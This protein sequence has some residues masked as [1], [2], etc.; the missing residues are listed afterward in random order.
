MMLGRSALTQF[1]V[2][3][4]RTRAA[5]IVAGLLCA[6][7]LWQRF[8]L[9][10]SSAAEAARPT[11]AIPVET[12]L[13]KRADL[14]VELEGLGTVQAF[15]TVKITPRVDG[16]LQR[17]RFVEGQVV[18]RGALLAQ[19]D[20]R[21]YRAVLQQAIASRD[22][23]ANQLANAARDLARYE[24]LAP[25]N[26]VSRQT[27]DTQRAL[28]GQLKAQLEGDRAA[29][30]AARTQLS[31]TTINSPIDGRTGLRLVDPG[32][33]VHASDATGIVIVTQ[34]QPISVIFTFPEDD[35][36]AVSRAL[37]AG[38]VRAVA[39]TRGG[40]K[41]LD[42]GTISVIDN[43]IDPTTG[44]MRLKA[45]FPNLDNR[46]WPG[47]F[48]KVRAQLGTDRHV[49]TIPAAAIQRG[50]EGEFAYVVGPDATV[51]AQQVTT[52]LES[53]ASVVVEKGLRDGARVVTSNQFRLQ[54]GARVRVLEAAQ[55]SS[56]AS[57]GSR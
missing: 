27:L 6:I 21:P 2:G 25:K 1:P 8:A 11:T 28:V 42:R 57:N 52:G 3:R 39:L 43:E 44:T 17:V 40:A 35:L 24:G 30:D 50:P 46:L 22:K 32:N 41:E 19:I 10:P 18:K 33:V 51:K 14:P 13:A 23:D 49:L 55:S 53:G 47:E 4:R 45:T 7:V 12:A 54:P 56:D 29:I 31:Y 26:L 20:P 34:M 38:P 16:E 15:Y 5:F 9:Q 48:V 36:V 37:A